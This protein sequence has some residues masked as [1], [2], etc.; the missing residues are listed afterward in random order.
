MLRLCLV[1]AL[2]AAGA[3]LYFGQMVIKPKIEQLNSD[4]TQTQTELGETKQAKDKSD[5][6]AKENKTAADKAIKELSDT[7]G[8]LESKTSEAA[9]QRTRADDLAGKFEAITKDHNE[10]KQ[11]LAAWAATALQP[12]Q[13]DD[14]KREAR[15]AKVER[16]EARLAI[17][18]LNKEVKALNS[19]LTRYKNPDAEV[20]LPAGLK[21]TITEVGAANDF[22]FL[23][24]GEAQGVLKGG[25]LLVRRGDK[26][27]SKVR[28][29][30]VA[31]NHSIA[32]VLPEWNQG[33]LNIQKGDAVLY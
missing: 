11:K 8:A 17:V 26:L 12:H 7:K 23:D 33:G 29:V 24:I 3:S 28:I 15:T 9:E 30:S 18:G 14:L 31:K 16:D 20:I 19:E 6:E 32:N 21:G 5:K 2:L 1:L 22:V 10:A 25:K 27:I 13:V 4:L